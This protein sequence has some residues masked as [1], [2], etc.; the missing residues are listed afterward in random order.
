MLPVNPWE[1][2]SWSLE[3]AVSSNGVWKAEQ[4]KCLL[5]SLK[6]L[7]RDL[8]RTMLAHKFYFLSL[9]V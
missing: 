1:M 4:I 5:S 9:E 7:C 2:L 8:L 3:D 6:V